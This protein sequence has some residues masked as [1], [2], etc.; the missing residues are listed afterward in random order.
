MKYLKRFE[1]VNSTSYKYLSEVNRNCTDILLELDDKGI[2]YNIYG[3]EGVQM[4]RHKPG[5]YIADMIT[6][7]IGDDFKTVKLKEFELE[8]EHLLSYLDGEGFKLNS[9]SYC[10][11]DTWDYHESCPE[12]DSVSIEELD[13][14]WSCSKCDYKGQLDDFRAPEHPLTM[15]DLKWYIK[16]NYYIQFMC[17][18][19]I[20]PR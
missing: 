2:I 13:D 20:K 12:C 7:E 15:S 8:L 3:S 11:N 6:I 10:M 14:Y 16:N 9:N 1:S 17:L 4:G 5:S 18:R 19:F